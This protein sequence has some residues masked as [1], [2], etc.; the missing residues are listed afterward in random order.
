M[1]TLLDVVLLTA[2][3]L[4]LGAII[5]NN[6]FKA[7]YEKLVA[8]L[9]PTVDPILAR[10]N[11]LEARI[12][13]AA[14]SAPPVPQFVPMPPP[15]SVTTFTPAPPGFIRA[16]DGVLLHP[17]T[18]A[19][20]WAA[21]VAASKAFAPGFVHGLDWNAVEWLRRMTPK[22]FGA[23]CFAVAQLPDVKAADPG[24]SNAVGWLTG[25]TVPG[26]GFFLNLVGD[27]HPALAIPDTDPRT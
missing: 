19:D 25:L 12:H 5:G 20:A 14:V 26:A 11:A 27:T 9:A 10:L 24:N 6:F 21:S 3:A 2:L 18:A 17:I 4:L 15:V 1:W 23:W 16:S 7:K 13:P 22:E 8:P